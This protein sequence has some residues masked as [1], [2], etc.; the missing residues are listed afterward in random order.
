MSEPSEITSAP[1]DARKAPTPIAR[2]QHHPGHPPSILR[3]RCRDALGFVAILGKPNVGKSTLL[4]TLLGVKVAPI[5]SK[6][7]TTRRGVAA[8]IPMSTRGVSS[9]SST[10]PVFTGPRRARQLHEP[11]GEN[12]RD[13]RRCDLVDGRPA[14]PH[15]ETRTRTWRGSCAASTRRRASISSATSSTPPNIPTKPW[16]F[17]ATSCPRSAAATR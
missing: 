17:T 2:H 16:P 6:P 5:T 14:P 8:S 7:Q 15:R 1:D 12:R 3:G 4:N 13:R 11:R 10:L 9:S